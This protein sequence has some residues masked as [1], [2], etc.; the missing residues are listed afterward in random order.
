MFAAHSAF[1]SMLLLV[2]PGGASTIAYAEETPETDN[3][4]LYIESE[5]EVASAQCMIDGGNQKDDKKRTDIG[6]GEKINLTLTGKRL[7]EV[8]L[9]S[10]EWSMEPDNVAMIKKSRE[11]KN[12]A[13]LTIN[14][15]LLQNTTLSI[16]VK[17]NLDEELP[18]GNPLIFNIFVPS[19]I[20]AAHTG[21]R[22]PGCALDGEKDNAGASSVLN[23]TLHPLKVSFSNIAFIERAKDPK[24]FK[25]K[26]NTGTVLFRPNAKNKATPSDH[27]GWKFKPGIRLPQLQNSNLPASFS[28]ACG[29]YVRAN[30]KDCL[31]IHGKTY[32]Q[33]FKF[34]YDGVEKDPMSPT[35]GLQNVKVTVSK[36]SCTV[37]R[38]TADKAL[39]I[40]S[41]IK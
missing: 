33:D 31:L 11:E 27:I 12:K 14:K 7:K 25:P 37:A 16:L 19:E 34:I 3:R 32:S 26:H 6:I 9:D 41:R 38:S 21:E 35:R 17:T 8:D 2:F 29:W 28:W 20:K 4:A 13:T 22:I 40:N 15:D 30:D 10:I 1:S 23:L 39:H 18:E 24:D 5:T 36:F